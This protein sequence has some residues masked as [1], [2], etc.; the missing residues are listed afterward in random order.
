MVFWDPNL[1]KRNNAESSF[2][3]FD[4]VKDEEKLEFKE[5]DNQCFLEK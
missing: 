3:D 1:Y 4:Y 5:I 2:A